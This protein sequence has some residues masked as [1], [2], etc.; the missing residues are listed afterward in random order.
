[1]F[2]KQSIG[3]TCLAV[4][5]ILGGF[6]KLHFLAAIFLLVALALSII[7]LVEEYKSDKRKNE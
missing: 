3:L 2:N 5:S 6:A 1:M 4:G 7:E